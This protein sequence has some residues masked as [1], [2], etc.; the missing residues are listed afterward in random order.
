MRRQKYLADWDRH[1]H[2]APMREIADAI[3][4]GDQGTGYRNENWHR[5]ISNRIRRPIAE[6]PL[7]IMHAHRAGAILG[8]TTL[9]GPPTG[10][11]LFPV[12]TSNSEGQ[13]NFSQNR[14]KSSSC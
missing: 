12:L 8:L 10:L 7:P 13:L 2:F 3:R 5:L 6:F 4:K 14:Q 11:T 9:A 1:I